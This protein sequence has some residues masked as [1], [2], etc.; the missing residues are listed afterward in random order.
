MAL[1]LDLEVMAQVI[2]G[3]PNFMLT[4]TALGWECTFTH[5]SRCSPNRELGRKFHFRFVT[6]K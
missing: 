3:C 4:V 2:R 6:V 5:R 1:C